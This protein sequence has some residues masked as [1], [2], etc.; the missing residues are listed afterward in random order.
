MC[1]AFKSVLYYL[2]HS[3]ILA[4]VIITASLRLGIS[5][6]PMHGP[7]LPRKM[8]LSLID[9]YNPLVKME[10]FFR[11]MIRPPSLFFL[12]FTAAPWKRVH[13]R[14]NLGLYLTIG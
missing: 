14:L 1:F 2:L 10:W 12:D 11:L 4:F 13:F 6:P 5:P 3:R 9:V 7:P 8:E